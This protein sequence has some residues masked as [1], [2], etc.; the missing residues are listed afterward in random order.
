[1]NDYTGFDPAGS[2]GSRLGAPARVA[3]RLGLC[4]VLFAG[5]AAACGSST[6][7]AQSAQP[8]LGPAASGGA[9]SVG[10][11]TTQ[12]A[13]DGGGFGTTG[14]ALADAGYTD[15]YQSST[16]LDHLAE[17]YAII[18]NGLPK[19]VDLN[20]TKAEKPGNISSDVYVLWQPMGRRDTVL[21]PGG[22]GERIYELDVDLGPYIT[23]GDAVAYVWFLSR[24]EGDALDPHDLTATPAA[25]PTQA[26]TFKL[27]SGTAG[28]LL[29]VFWV[30]GAAPTS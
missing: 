4:L 10:F 23:G 30:K 29:N 21:P 8:S 7:S 28:A 11:D 9:P 14:S 6:S 19:A 5:V 26:F 17:A 22:H 25:Y 12:F 18:V 13:L 2:R 1:M 3:I 16:G 15:R 20:Q 27:D 24:A